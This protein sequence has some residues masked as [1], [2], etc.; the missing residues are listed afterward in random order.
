[1]VKCAFLK[2]HKT[3]LVV[4][5]NKIDNRLQQLTLRICRARCAIAATA[6]TQVVHHRFPHLR[7]HDS[8]PIHLA[9]SE[10]FRFV[11]TLQ[12]ASQTAI[13]RARREGPVDIFCGF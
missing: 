11:D 12:M 1:M 7:E 8:P 4:G 5:N 2:Q 10:V 3:Y 9:Q 6:T 13:S